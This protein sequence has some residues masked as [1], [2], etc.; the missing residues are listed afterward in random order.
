MVLEATELD[1]SASERKI[2]IKADLTFKSLIIELVKKLYF[3]Y[4]FLSV[5]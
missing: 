2:K 3:D 4:H 1:E 5:N